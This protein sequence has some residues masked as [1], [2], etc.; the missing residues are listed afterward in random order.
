MPKPYTVKSKGGI[1]DELCVTKT[2]ENAISCLSRS[3]QSI[4]KIIVCSSLDVK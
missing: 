1:F 4:T 2:I 3:M